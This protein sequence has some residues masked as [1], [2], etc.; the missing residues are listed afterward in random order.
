MIKRLP[1]DATARAVTAWSPEPPTP[2]QIEEVGGSWTEIVSRVEAL[3]VPMLP[4][5]IQFTEVVLDG[6][7]P[8]FR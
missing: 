2:E 5:A 4:R 3:V 6:D 8:H 7:T 1:L